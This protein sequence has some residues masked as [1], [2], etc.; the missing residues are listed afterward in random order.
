MSDAHAVEPGEPGEK[1]KPPGLPE[2]RDEAADSP[3]WLPL[4]GLGVLLALGGIFGMEIWRA[5]RASAEQA[6]AA[7][8]A[9]A[10]AAPADD[11]KVDGAPAGD[12]RPVNDPTPAAQ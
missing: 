12:A 11:A 1:P 3:S 6:Q 5:H 10:V 4:V 9:A 2:I 8:A 7:A